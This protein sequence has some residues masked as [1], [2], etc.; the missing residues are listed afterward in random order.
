M[1]GEAGE[2]GRGASQPASASARQDVAESTSAGS[3]AYLA[4]MAHAEV[5]LART[6]NE[7]V[8][9]A[10]DK[11]EEEEDKPEEQEDKPE[12]QE[13]ADY[14]GDVPSEEADY[15]GDDDKQ[16]EMPAENEMAILTRC[17]ADLQDGRYVILSARQTLEEWQAF[18]GVRAIVEQKLRDAKAAEGASQPPGEPIEFGYPQREE[19]LEMLRQRWLDSGAPA[20]KKCKF[21]GTQ[22]EWEEKELR[23]GFPS[24]GGSQRLFK[25]AC[26]NH[27]RWALTSVVSRRAFRPRLGASPAFAMLR[28]WTP[29]IAATSARQAGLD[30]LRGLL[31]VPRLKA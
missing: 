31:G 21:K 7:A 25:R 10:A 29:E 28:G 12:E 9:A 16:D 1:G 2:W 20:S 17:R 19:C 24:F 15:S 8:A 5:Q 11:P 3:Q 23:E 6:L 26:A 30:G 18:A 13:E 4:V 27:W 22:K 14:S